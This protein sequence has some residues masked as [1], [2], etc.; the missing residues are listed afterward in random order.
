MHK[1]RTF[2]MPEASIVNR[3]NAYM[4]MYDPRGEVRNECCGY[5]HLNPKG[6]ICFVVI[7]SLS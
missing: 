4:L 5:K 6:S 2:K 1:K 3:T 7:K